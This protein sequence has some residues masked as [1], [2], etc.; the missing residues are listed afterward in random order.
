MMTGMH[1]LKG[2]MVIGIFGVNSLAQN[3]GMLSTFVRLYIPFKKSLIYF[4]HEM[5]SNKGARD[6]HTT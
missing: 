1:V 2:C 5:R 6:A 3:A 4:Q